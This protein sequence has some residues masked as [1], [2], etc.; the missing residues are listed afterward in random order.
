LFFKEERAV[1]FKE[2]RAEFLGDDK[3]YFFFLS[4]KLVLFFA[5][6]FING[7]KIIFP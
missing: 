1:V 3:E 5:R 6:G 2:E 7:E 4:Q